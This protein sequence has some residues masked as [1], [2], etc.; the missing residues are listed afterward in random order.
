MKKLSLVAC[1]AILAGC[2]SSSPTPQAELEKNV[3]RNIAAKNEL[4]FKET[5]GK[6]L[7][8]EDAQK[9]NECVAAALTTQLT[10]NEKLV[11]GGN[12][13]EKLEAKND[14]ESA[15]KKITIASSESKA[16]IKTC[17]TTLG[18]AKAISKIKL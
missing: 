14:L 1:A 17:G 2:L 8:E 7:N 5:F 15:S 11:L 16:A 9:L 6:A 18:V 10:Q 13:K 3:E 4:L 12:A